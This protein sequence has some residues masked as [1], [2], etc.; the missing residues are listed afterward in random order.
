MRK[1]GSAH[2]SLSFTNS[3]LFIETF[4]VLFCF[5]FISFHFVHFF[6]LLPTLHLI[7]NRYWVW[8][9]VKGERSLFFTVLLPTTSTFTLFGDIAL[10]SSSSLH[11]S[12]KCKNILCSE[13]EDITREKWYV[14]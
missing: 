14:P 2:L 3:C 8:Q 12:T 4:L 9:M 1:S 6:S 13:I 11:R 5:V 10:S 7:P